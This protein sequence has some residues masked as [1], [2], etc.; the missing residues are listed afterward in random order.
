MRP[1]QYSIYL[2][3]EAEIVL[4]SLTCNQRVTQLI[5]T[6]PVFATKTGPFF[7]YWGEHERTPIAL[8]YG[9]APTGSREK[10]R[11]ADRRDEYTC[12]RSRAPQHKKK[13]SQRSPTLRS[14]SRGFHYFVTV[15]G[16]A[17]LL[18][19]NSSFL[20]ASASSSNAWSAF[21]VSSGNGILGLPFSIISIALS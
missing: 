20:S 1:F 4:H 14:L 19:A 9:S 13:A 10:E 18:R 3:A 11:S 17:Y 7:A 15:H 2:W 12:S 6:C 5:L 16:F 8:G 21:L